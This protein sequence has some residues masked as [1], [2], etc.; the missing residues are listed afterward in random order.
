MKSKKIVIAFL[1]CLLVV[2][3]IFITH[4]TNEP[5]ENEEFKVSTIDVS[6]SD[7]K[8]ETNIEDPQIVDIDD[9]DPPL[10]TIGKS[11]T[12]KVRNLNS[13][14]LDTIR[15]YLMNSVNQER[16]TKANNQ[17]VT[18]YDKLEK[19]GDIRAKEI[20]QRWSHTR[21]NGQSWSTVLSANGINHSNLKA[22]EDLAKITASA[23]SS[24]SQDFLKQ[25]SDTLHQTLMASPT[26]KHVM[27]N[28]TY[29]EIGIGVYS[30]VKNGK[31][32]VY[33]TEHF[34]NAEPKQ[35]SVSKVNVSKLIYS[36]ISNKVYTGKQIKPSLTVKYKGKTL[37]NGT[38][39]TL[40]YGANKSTGK[41]TVKVTGKGNYTG[42]VTKTFY[43]VPKA[44]ASV[45][46]TAGK[47][48]LTVKYGKS[49]GATGYEILYS[50]NKTSGF[51]K[52]T[53]TGASKTIS[54]L[55]S[56]KTYYVKARAYKTVSGKKYYSSYSA[57][58]SVKVK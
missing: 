28:Q 36:S 56:K 49:V 3:I 51:K 27:L 22:G 16:K 17:L 58:K 21:P 40:S 39:Y 30:E 23:K 50:T 13:T 37:K 52:V 6:T 25:L 57:V 46:L 20:L 55:T 19:T 32:N 9:D 41:A 8:T 12:T 45:K 15:D 42:S 5:S 48:A 29:Q 7:G 26:H 34:K 53:L 54:K 11:D 44:P 31:V 1:S 24:Y 38:D 43:I 33:I 35:T 18:K 4:Q 2:G 10:A 47:K 14:E